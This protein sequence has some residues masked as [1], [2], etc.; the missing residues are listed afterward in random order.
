MNMLGE[1]P[2][3]EVVFNAEE[4]SEVLRILQEVT[5]HH[6]EEFLACI[7]KVRRWYK[8]DRGFDEIDENLTVVRLILRRMNIRSIF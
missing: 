8:G 2:G 7:E 4:S 1:N 5:S 6:R 3:E